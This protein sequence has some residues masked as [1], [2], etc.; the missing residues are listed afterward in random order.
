MF[1]AK[2]QFIYFSDCISMVGTPRIGG[3]T[4]HTKRDQLPA[5]TH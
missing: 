1:L 4:E 2:K 5:A 3:H